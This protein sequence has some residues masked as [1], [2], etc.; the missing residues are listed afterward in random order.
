[1][2][3]VIDAS[4]ILPWRFEDEAT[5]W[6]ESLLDRVEGGEEAVA[7]AHWPLELTNSL[8]TAVRRGRIT[9][10]QAEEF[11]EDLAALPIRIEPASGPAQWPAVLRLAGQLRLT[12]YDAAYIELARRAVLPLATLDR[13]LQKAAQAIGV[14]LINGY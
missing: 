11:A 1:M 5:S 9:A 8:L 6:T 3:F 10:A 12:A 2:A 4:A 13:D 7:P 14:P